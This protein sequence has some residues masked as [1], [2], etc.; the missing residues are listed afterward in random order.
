ME[1]E[2][3]KPIEGEVVTGEW[4]NVPA[5]IIQTTWKTKLKEATGYKPRPHFVKI[6]P[7]RKKKRVMAKIMYN[8]GWG[9]RQLSLW[10]REP[11]QNITNWAKMP[12]PEGLM[13]FEG[14]F[15]MAMK[16]YDNQAMYK[17]KERILELLPEEKDINKLVKAGEFFRG[18][19]IKNQT[20]VQNNVYGDLIKK[21][22]PEAE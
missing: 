17:T 7:D 2:E 11:M 19:I 12:T 16:D 18:P 15:R 6:H 13:A 1:T 9:S 3:T 14:E 22:S 20:N 8:A 21:F 4:K 5:K 10:F